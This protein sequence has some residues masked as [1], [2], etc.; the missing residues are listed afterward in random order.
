MATKAED[1]TT[2]RMRQQ[3]AVDL[4]TQGR[5]YQQIADALAYADASGAYRAVMAVLSRAEHSAAEG[6]RAVQGARLAALEAAWLPRADSDPKAAELVLKIHQ[7]QARLFGLD[8][9]VKVDHTISDA[10]D[11]AVADL[12]DQ[13]GVAAGDAPV[14]A[15]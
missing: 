3:K 7:R 6:L 14:P 15:E 12:A 13:L 8:A 1:G 9:P 11:R 10:T 4:A 5:T 2:A